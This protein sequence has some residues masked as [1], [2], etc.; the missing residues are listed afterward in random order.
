MSDVGVGWNRYGKMNVRMMRLIRDSPRHEVHEYTA[1]I[2]IESPLFDS[3]YEQGDNTWVVPTDTQKNTLYVMAK[4][5]PVEPL[6]RW[7]VLVAKEFLARHTHITSIFIHV[8]R[9]PWEHVVV[10]GKEHNHAF[11]KGVSGIR[12]TTTKLGRNGELSL[13]SGF[14]DLTIMKTTLSGFYGYIKDEYTNLRETTDRVLA[15]KMECEWEFR[16]L[17]LDTDFTSIFNAIHQLTIEKFVGDPQTGSYSASVQQTLYDIGSTVLKQN[18][19][20]DKITFKLPNIHYFPVNFGDFS[21]DLKNNGE[22]F[23]T[24]DGAHGQIEAT[25]ERKTAKL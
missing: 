12:F 24:F 13:S 9:H 23:Y 16:N 15:T 10:K 17:N 3:A 5:H 14:K 4:K 22:V 19:V 6:E 7:T 21:T 18:E 2:M 20:I 8:D 1:Q 25:L 11:M